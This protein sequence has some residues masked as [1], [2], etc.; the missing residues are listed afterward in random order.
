M[1]SISQFL[2]R[3]SLAMRT[4]RTFSGAQIKDLEK[5][6]G[7]SLRTEV[8]GEQADTE[9]EHFVKEYFAKNHWKLT[10]QDDTTRLILSKSYPNH[11]VKI[12]YE[13]KIPDTNQQEEGEEETTEEN[14]A[15]SEY[16]DF[17]VVV[18]KKKPTKL[19][20]NLYFTQGEIYIN[21]LFFTP[22]A[23]ELALRKVTSIDKYP[24]PAIDTLE[25]TLQ[26]RM[27]LYLGG[28]GITAE[29][30]EVLN[31]SSRL[32]EEKLYRSFLDEFKRFVE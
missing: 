23:E 2:R 18:D 20:A 3:S 17:T 10:S 29:L 27:N 26:T 28:L 1:K 6:L 15:P 32:H 24:G 12:F 13:A 16:L 14:Q 25:E 7:E 5:K 30:A 11:E 19:I 31:Q 4:D 8:E 9:T 22:Q 21:E